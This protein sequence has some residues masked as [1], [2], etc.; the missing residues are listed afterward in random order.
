MQ[1]FEL[2][3]VLLNHA[4]FSA[5][6]ILRAVDAEG[7]TP[8]HIA[9]SLGHMRGK[10]EERMR[11]QEE[12]MRTLL[13]PVRGGVG[14]KREGLEGTDGASDLSLMDQRNVAGD[15][16][17]QLREER[18]R[19]WRHDYAAWESYQAA[20]KAWRK[21][22][23]GYGPPPEWPYKRDSAWECGFWKSLIEAVCIYVRRISNVIIRL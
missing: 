23:R 14:E 19:R 15:T 20:S 18:W 17:R 13:P 9:A 4:G 8:L 12:M 22:G 21:A 1:L 11:A 3:R 5:E 16:P 6:D 10:P 7:N 2:V